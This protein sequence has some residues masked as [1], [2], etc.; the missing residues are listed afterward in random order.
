[1][2]R[3]SYG[4]DIDPLGT[5]RCPTL[6]EVHGADQVRT[7]LWL[8]NG[9]RNRLVTYSVAPR[10]KDGGVPFLDPDTQSR[11]FT[12]VRSECDWTPDPLA[13]DDPQGGSAGP[14][15]VGDLTVLSEY[16]L[17]ESHLAGDEPALAANVTSAKVTCAPREGYLE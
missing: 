2:G 9:D 1:V 8:V 16:L 11:V 4:G 3:S 12:L 7:L 5:H 6:P 14:N 13:P 15:M 17:P 10:Y